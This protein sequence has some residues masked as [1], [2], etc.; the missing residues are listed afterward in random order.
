MLLMRSALEQMYKNLCKNVIAVKFIKILSG[1]L[2]EFTV[3]LMCPQ[4][5]IDGH[6]RESIKGTAKL[7]PLNTAHANSDAYD[8]C[9]TICCFRKWHRAGSGSRSFKN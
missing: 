3:Y 7:H 5:H 4:E 1:L 8:A 9:E 6:Q 2:S